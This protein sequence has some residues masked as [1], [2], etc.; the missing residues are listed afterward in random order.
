MVIDRGTA[1]QEIHKGPQPQSRGCGGTDFFCSGGLGPVNQR[2]RNKKKSTAGVLSKISK[3]VVGKDGYETG[4]GGGGK[5]TPKKK[6]KEHAK[7]DGG[8]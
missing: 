5:P 8:I 3:F 1:L 6:E 7:N 4:W 2:I